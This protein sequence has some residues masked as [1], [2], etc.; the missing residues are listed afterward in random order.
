[1]IIVRWSLRPAHG[2]HDG[3]GWRFQEISSHCESRTNPILK[4]PQLNITS[5]TPA[6]VAINDDDILCGT[7]RQ[8]LIQ[9]TLKRPWYKTSQSTRHSP[10]VRQLW[11]PKV[12]F[13]PASADWLDLHWKCRKY[14]L[15]H[16]AWMVGACFDLLF[17]GFDGN[18]FSVDRL[19]RG[20][21]PILFYDSAKD[22]APTERTERKWYQLS[23][24]PVGCCFVHVA[25]RGSAD[26]R[27]FSISELLIHFFRRPSLSLSTAISR[28]ISRL[29]ALPLLTADTKHR[30]WM[31]SK[32]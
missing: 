5:Y 17:V 4:W 7:L 8:Q 31:I 32:E 24:R 19:L 9:L 18:A 29:S 15:L 3:C 1:M 14:L 25:H 12:L 26:W 27:A 6:H 13:S 16:P 2:F 11:Q 21:R 23:S 30:I 28:S 22:H 10:P 20:T